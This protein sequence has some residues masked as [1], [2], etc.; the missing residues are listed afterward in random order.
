VLV[1]KQDEHHEDED[2]ADQCRR[3]QTAP[4]QVRRHLQGTCVGPHHLHRHRILPLRLPRR[5]KRVR[6]TGGV[7][8]PVQV[9]QRDGCLVQGAAAGSR[10][11]QEPDFFF[12][13]GFIAR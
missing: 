7:D 11:L 10:R 12:K 8:L 9:A 5:C 13:I 2:E 4:Q 1:L 6:R 3:L